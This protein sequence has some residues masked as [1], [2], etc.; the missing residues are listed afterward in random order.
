[1]YDFERDPRS[2]FAK[3]LLAHWREI[4]PPGGVPTRAALD[5]LKLRRVLPTIFIAERQPAGE[6]RFRL[7]GEEVRGRNP[8]AVKGADFLD[9]FAAQEGAVADRLVTRALETPCGVF[10][11]HCLVQ[12]ARLVGEVEVV[13]LPLASEAGGGADAVVGVANVIPVIAA[14]TTPGEP[15]ITKLT[16]WRYLDVG[17]GTPDA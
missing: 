17:F 9:V 16:S 5:P 6:L 10:T 3:P 1:M 8:G 7:V 15:A 4:Q 12:R 2:T 11:T 14:P 13:F